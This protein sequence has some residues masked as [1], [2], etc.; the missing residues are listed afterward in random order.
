MGCDPPRHDQD[1][2]LAA[3][4][5]AGPAL[6]LEGAD[7]VL[8]GGGT[9]ISFLDRERAEPDA[10]LAGT[11]WTV[12]TLVDGQTAGSVPAGVRAHLSFTADGK[13]TGSGGCNQLTG[14]YS[15]NGDAITFTDMG[16]TF[17]A[18]ADDRGKV[19]GKVLPVLRGTV[20]YRIEADH[21]TL[22]A[23]NGTGL[24]LTAGGTL[25]SPS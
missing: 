20:R 3:F 4:L 1:T 10:P 8:E 12:D 16:S 22:T 9:T 24:R 17:M 11:V 18:C 21:L 5:Q 6:R 13:V 7:L 25:P 15:A 2:W 14:S 23:A 19:E